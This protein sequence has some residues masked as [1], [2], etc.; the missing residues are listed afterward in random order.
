MRILV[1]GASGVLGRSTL[2]HLD[3]HEVIGLT[4]T[5]D[6]LQ[7]L[8]DLGAEGIVCDV[9]DYP[10][11]MR[12]AQRARPQIVVNFLT[13]LSAGSDEGNTRV[14]REGGANLLNAAKAANAA[15]LVVESVAFPLHGDAAR[16]LEQLEHSTHRFPGEALIL[17][18][19]R[20]WGPETLHQTPPQP[21]A[22]HIEKAG[23]EAS[24]LITHAPPGT[25]VVT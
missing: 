7:L 17:R 2:P 21:P 24:T 15:R 23:A 10:T 1:A 19:G 20:I 9:Y 8:R 16:A 13:D 12:V 25:Y 5:G 6:K 11:L 3:R 4:R 22:V 14:R 18:F